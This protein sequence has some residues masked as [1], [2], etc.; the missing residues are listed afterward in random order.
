MQVGKYKVTYDRAYRN[1]CKGKLSI[2]S[3]NVDDPN[4]RYNYVSVT[5]HSGG[6][7]IAHIGHRPSVTHH[8]TLGGFDTPLAALNAALGELRIRSYEHG[9][10]EYAEAYRDRWLPGIEILDE[11]PDGWHVK[12]DTA[13]NPSG[14]RWASNGSLFSGNYKHALL[15]IG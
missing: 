5:H 3:L 15:Y 9:T 4:G 12:E 13:T 11:L 2:L 14:T 1:T 7:F 10:R 8:R 6:E